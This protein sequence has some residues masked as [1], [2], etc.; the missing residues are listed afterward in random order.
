MLAHLL[1]GVFFFCITL[2]A[3]TFVESI[4]VDEGKTLIGTK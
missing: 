2:V 1:S 4:L 3:D